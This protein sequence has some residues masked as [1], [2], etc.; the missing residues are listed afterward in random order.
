VALS[1]VID[2]AGLRECCAAE[3]WVQQM[4]AGAPYASTEEL[5]DA[6]ERAFDAL[7]SDDWAQAFGGHARI[8]EPRSGD[9]RGSVEQVGATD[10]DPATRAALRAGNVAYEE[11]FGHVFLIRAAGLTA[12]EMLSALS[13]R[14]H[15]T[16]EAEFHTATEQQREITRLRLLN[17]TR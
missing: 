15:N 8:G 6:S 2:P 14:L 3:R 7:A 10:T 9:A 11:R 13:R 17:L 12:E 4:L 16:P 5:L 1:Q